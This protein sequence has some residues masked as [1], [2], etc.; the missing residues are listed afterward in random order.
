[1]RHDWIPLDPADIAPGRS[2]TTAGASVRVTVFPSPYDVP[3]AVRGYF[4]V[5]LDRFV[6][7]FRYLFDDEIQRFK[8][9]E[10]IT[11]RIGKRTK[12]VYGLEIDSQ[13][14][15][16]GNVRLELIAK[17]IEQTSKQAQAR[18]RTVNY[19]IA[20]DVLEKRKQDLFEVGAL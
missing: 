4:S 5:E 16:A 11:L 14:V 12:R 17:A 13:L 8:Q 20:R 19:S 10:L 1:M 2:E 7:E 15:G 18:D 6:I 9:S 3:G